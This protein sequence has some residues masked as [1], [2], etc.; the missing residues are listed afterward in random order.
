MKKRT[1]M[2]KTAL[3]LPL[4]LLVII[5]YMTV[6]VT[7]DIF[8]KNI[9]LSPPTLPQPGYSSQ[10]TID[11]QVID[12]TGEFGYPW[13]SQTSRTMVPLRIISENMGYEV[14]WDGNVKLVTIKNATTTVKIKVGESVATVNGKIVNIDYKDGKVVDT[15]AVIVTNRTYVPI[16]FISEAMGGEVGF[17]MNPAGK[18]FITITTG[19]PVLP[20][21][22]TGITFN[23]ATD[24][25]DDGTGRMSEEK[26]EEFI[27]EI[28]KN[29]KVEKTGGKYYFS[30]DKVELPSGFQAGLK[31]A[32]MVNDM[33][34]PG[35]NISATTGN[36]IMPHNQLPR[37]SSFKVELNKDQMDDIRFATLYVSV[38]AKSYKG[39][40]AVSL[41]Y[42]IKYYPDGEASPYYATWNKWGSRS[43][44]R[45]PFDKNTVF[46]G[47]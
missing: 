19:K 23:P 9:P 2:K 18:H 40:T 39:D 42:E 17:K 1:T 25:L 43:N 3:P 45:Y 5:M 33:T 22:E 12:F 26:T 38:G 41:M 46:I 4:L 37:D 13:L 30:Y 28:I 21:V 35:D 14:E 32:V 27:Q 16:R 10:I 47:F 44:E 7:P 29:V 20:P 6:S 11:G 34:T 31:L 8:G 36:A 15:K 24:L